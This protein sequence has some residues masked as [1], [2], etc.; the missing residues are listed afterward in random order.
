MLY[1][2][3]KL[4]YMISDTSEVDWT[5]VDEVDISPQ[6]LSKIIDHFLLSL[7]P[8]HNLPGSDW[9][10]LQGIAIWIK[11]DKLLT[12]RQRRYAIVTMALNWNQLDITKII[13]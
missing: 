9:F 4:N 11:Q 2:I 8:E 1:E 5:Y 6:R 7:L 10:K 13:T 3:E 12:D